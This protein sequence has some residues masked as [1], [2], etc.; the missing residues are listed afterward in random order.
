MSSPQ[1]SILLIGCAALSREITE[2]GRLNHWDHVKTEW[3]P[4]DLHNRPEKIAPAVSELIEQG[5]T[6]FDEII[7]AYGDCGTGGKLDAVLEEY[8][9]RRLPGDHCYAFFAG[10]DRFAELHDEEPGSFYLTDFLVRNFDRLVIRG[11]GLDRYP[12]LHSDYF[13]HYRRVV[14]LAQTRSSELEDKARDCARKLDL[15]FVYRFTGLAPFE[16]S[17]AVERPSER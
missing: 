8:G 3:L 2:V 12:E 7:V 14:Y 4:A 16:G 9:I 15:E 17:L 11:L 13:R 5:L 1:K 6:E 10:P